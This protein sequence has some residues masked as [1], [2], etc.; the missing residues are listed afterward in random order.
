M[1]I[2][3]SI[4]HTY[5][6]IEIINKTEFSNKKLNHLIKVSLPD[7]LKNKKI[8]LF[9]LNAKSYKKELKSVGLASYLKWITTCPFIGLSFI[10]QEKMKHYW[11]SRPVIIVL[12]SRKDR[13]IR[14]PRDKK[15]GYLSHTTKTKE[16][17]FVTILSHELKH[18]MY[19]NQ[20]SEL[21]DV[22]EETMCDKYALRR[23]KAYRNMEK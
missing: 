23:L 19:S 13:V 1:R 15:Q 21:N 12:V 16:E 6:K 11:V 9:A 2:P 14:F 3:R 20:V 7:K 4:M 8:L 22:L 5:K 10:A 18:I 17:L